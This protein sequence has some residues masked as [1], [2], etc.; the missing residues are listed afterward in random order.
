MGVQLF[1]LSSGQQQKKDKM[2]GMIS[3]TCT[4]VS[5]DFIDFILGSKLGLWGKSRTANK[6]LWFSKS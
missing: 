3:F 1:T 2:G 4:Y 5:S 6:I